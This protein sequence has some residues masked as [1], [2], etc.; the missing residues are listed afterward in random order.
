MVPARE[1]AS[2]IILLGGM[3]TQFYD[4]KVGGE[5]LRGLVDIFG[6]EVKAV[7]PEVRDRM[8]LSAQFT[9]GDRGSEDILNGLSEY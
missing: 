5:V 8:V 3:E 9:V 6:R 1:L 7:Y 2:E 4:E